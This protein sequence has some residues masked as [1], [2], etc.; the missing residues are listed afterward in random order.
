MNYFPPAKLIVFFIISVCKTVICLND[1]T[2]MM[3]NG[4][5]VCRCL[6]NCSSER[7]QVREK[8]FF[9]KEVFFLFR[10][11]AHRMEFYIEIYAN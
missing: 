9:W 10:R 4:V 8:I 5:Q 2:C 1:K 3:E 6:F 11:Y 7:K